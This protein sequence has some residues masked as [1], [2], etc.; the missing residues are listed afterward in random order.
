MILKKADLEYLVCR[1]SNAMIPE[2]LA[3]AAAAAKSLQSCPTLYSP[4]DGSP[5]GSS[6]PGILQARILEWVAISFSSA[7]MHA[8]SLQSCLNQSCLVKLYFCFLFKLLK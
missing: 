7:Y 8:K 3:A 5:P 4:T 6:V 2:L 1:I